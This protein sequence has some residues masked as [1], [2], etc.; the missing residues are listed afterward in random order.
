MFLV[1]P[2]ASL[3]VGRGH[4][5]T[6]LDLQF[7]IGDPSVEFGTVGTSLFAA[8]LTAGPRL[9]LGR[10]IIDLDAT[11][12]LGWCWMRGHVTDPNAIPGSGS[13][14]VASAGGRVG[15]ILPTAARVSH[16]RAFLE[17]G[18]M[19]H[20]LQA[21]VNDVAGAAVAGGYLLFG[22]GFGENR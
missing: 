14:L 15:M 8:S 12:R 22:F 18:G 3:A 16:L 21:E 13:A 4:W 19:I 9:P 2:A 1:G 7:L 5:Q 17:G 20:G 10:V 11:G 6:A